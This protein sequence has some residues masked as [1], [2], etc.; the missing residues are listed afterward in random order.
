VDLSGGKNQQAAEKLASITK[1]KVV[2]TLPEGEVASGT[3][4]LILCIAMLTLTCRNHFKLRNATHI[5][6]TCVNNPTT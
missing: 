3:E 2:Q 5:L 1:G 6:M 4:I